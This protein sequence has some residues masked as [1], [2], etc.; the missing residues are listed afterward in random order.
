M[1]AREQDNSDQLA[2]DREEVGPDHADWD[3]VVRTVFLVFCHPLLITDLD[4][5]RPLE[6]EGI[7]VNL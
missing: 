7:L 2:F 6:D 1:L 3:A 4:D 5:S